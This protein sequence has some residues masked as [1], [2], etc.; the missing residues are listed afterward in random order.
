MPVPLYQSPAHQ[1]IIHLIGPQRP[2]NA[3]P[4]KVLLKGLGNAQGKGDI[5]GGDGHMKHNL[6]FKKSQLSKIHNLANPH[7]VTKFVH[8]NQEM[9]FFYPPNPE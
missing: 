4:I 9:P 1:N 3:L 2:D 5:E 6:K 8:T 7:R